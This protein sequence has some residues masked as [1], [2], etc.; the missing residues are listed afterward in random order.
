MTLADLHGPGFYY[1]VNYRRRDQPNAAFV[2]ATISDYTQRQH[3]VSDQP[4]MTEYE[5]YV[6]ASNSLGSAD[7]EPKKMI[8]YSGEGSKSRDL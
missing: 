3:I 8:G 1:T 7:T 2:S 4:T 6:T 5:I